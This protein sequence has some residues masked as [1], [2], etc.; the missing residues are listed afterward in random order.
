M[1]P[2]PTALSNGGGAIRSG[3]AALAAGLLLAACAGT[4]YRGPPPPLLHAGSLPPVAEADILEMTPDMQAFVD[5]FAPLHADPPTR[6]RLLVGALA[7]PA[8][9]GFHYVED[10]TLTA[11]AAFEQ[12]S[13][14]CVA[15]SNLLV[16][17]GRAARL[18]ARFQEVVQEPVWSSVEDTL[19]VSRHINVVIEH[20]GHRTA[21]DVSGYEFSPNQRR[22][23]VSDTE[24]RALFYSN[25]GAEAL[26]GDDLPLAYAYLV[27]AIEIEPRL[28]DPWANLGVVLGRNGQLADA[29]EAYRVALA[30]DRNEYAA[31]SNL[32]AAYQA[33]GEEAAALALQPRVERY[34]QRNPY[35]LMRLSEEALTAGRHD[36]ALR[37]IERAID[38]KPE[39][40]RFYAMLARVQ[41][42]SGEPLAAE[43]SLGRARDLAPDGQLAHDARPLEEWVRED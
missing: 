32:Y 25:I 42:L 10:R 39:E 5:R 7:S 31:L 40:H 18:D 24:A 19:L 37:L 33:L 38:K 26:L 30:L 23:A 13:G 2:F 34:R 21:V 12:R 15:F 41:Y 16:A 20:R 9:L 6:L 36:E 17:M 43:A 22:R 8:V 35:H 14:N 28:S 11:R 27:K 1:A 4:V 29:V 3:L